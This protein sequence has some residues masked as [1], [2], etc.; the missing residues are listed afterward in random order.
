MAELTNLSR[1][2][3]NIAEQNRRK[4]ISSWISRLHKGFGTTDDYI[5]SLSLIMMPINGVIGITHQGPSR[6]L[7]II[8]RPLKVLLN[9][10]VTE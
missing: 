3:G 5:I 1:E 7:F 8:W 6:P 10:L 9:Q 4:G 2:L